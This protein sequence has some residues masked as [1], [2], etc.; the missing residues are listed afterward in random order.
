MFGDMFGGLFGPERDKIIGQVVSSSDLVGDERGHYFVLSKLDDFAA[1]FLAVKL[2]NAE[3]KIVYGKPTV[4]IAHRPTLLAHQEKQKADEQR[5]RQVEFQKAV[6][7][8]YRELHP[9][10]YP[11]LSSPWGRLMPHSKAPA[12]TTCRA[13]CFARKSL[14]FSR[15]QKEPTSFL[16]TFCDG[17]RALIEAYL[18]E[19][20]D[21]RPAWLG[22][23]E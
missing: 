22:E 17:H 23:E 15:P 5:A 4:V 13:G 7:A 8:Y 2:D 3:D 11:S 6:V 16:D 1:L 19:N 12:A 18:T 20:P 14:V 21:A 10:L 9:G